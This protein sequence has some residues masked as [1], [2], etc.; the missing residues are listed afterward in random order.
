[1]NGQ[2]AHLSVIDLMPKQQVANPMP[3]IIAPWSNI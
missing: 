1:M 3:G 2:V